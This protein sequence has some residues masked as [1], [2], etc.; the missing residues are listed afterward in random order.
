MYVGW[1]RFE[2]ERNSLSK[3]SLRGQRFTPSV[4][5]MSQFS[6]AFRVSSTFAALEFVLITHDELLA[7]IDGDEKLFLA[8]DA[9]WPS[10]LCWF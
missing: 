7:I 3:G 8:A 2:H 10:F 1:H 9:N 5:S 4:S 6:F